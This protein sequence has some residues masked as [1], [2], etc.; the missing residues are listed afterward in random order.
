MTEGLRECLGLE[1]SENSGDSE[2]RLSCQSDFFED[3]PWQSGTVRG[4]SNKPRKKTLKDRIKSS[5]ESTTTNGAEEGEEDQGQAVGNPFD[6][7]STG[8]G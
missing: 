8:M 7:K 1:E 6:T 3:G 4:N 2:V 5:F